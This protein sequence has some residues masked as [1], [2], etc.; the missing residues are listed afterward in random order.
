MSNIIREQLAEMTVVG[1]E[2]KLERLSNEDLYALDVAIG[3]V[4]KTRAQDA[5]LAKTHQ[6]I[7]LMHE[8][9]VFNAGEVTEVRFFPVEYENGYFFADGMVYGRFG[10]TE[11][12]RDE[13]EGFE[14]V[15]GDVSA[16]WTITAD[17]VLHVYPYVGPGGSVQVDE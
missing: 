13:V 6:L 7:A 1:D 15:M 14:S 11:F 10:K 16:L 3:R 17:S 8:Q 4:L 2:G 9:G 12:E 5:V